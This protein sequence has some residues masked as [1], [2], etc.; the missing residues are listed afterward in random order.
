MNIHVCIIAIRNYNLKFI[1]FKLS[2]LIQKPQNTAKYSLLM[3]KS[4]SF[5]P[6][7][8]PVSEITEIYA[9]EVIWPQNK[10]MQN[11][12]FCIQY[13]CKGMKLTLFCFRPHLSSRS[14]IVFL[15]MQYPCLCF[16]GHVNL[17]SHQ[18]LKF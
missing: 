3:K 10:K 17:S 9:F 6:I 5:F 14:K 15:H 8:L 4:A 7:S 1:N 12:Y 13:P 11:W 16:R 2:S 18:K